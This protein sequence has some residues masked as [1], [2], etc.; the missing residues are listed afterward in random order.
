MRS[1][2]NHR[3]IGLMN[4]VVVSAAFALGCG[5]SSIDPAASRNLKAVA[6]L[7]C[8]F[9]FSH[10]SAGPADEQALKKHARGMDRRSIEALQID[11]NQ[12]DVVFTSPRDQ[13][14][15]R[16]RYGLGVSDLGRNAPLLAHEQTG[17]RGKRLA[18][19]ANGRVEELDD[20]QLQQL[21]DGKKAN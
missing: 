13:Q 20:A 8:D 16:V 14:P 11:I 21:I 17:A 15:L 9:A 2:G 18:V 12:L 4:A 7:Y 19:F 1:L 5:G 6:E 3:R 10:K